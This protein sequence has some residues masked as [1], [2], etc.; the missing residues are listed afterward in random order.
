MVGWKIVDEN[1]DDVMTAESVSL[2]AGMRQ[3]TPRQFAQKE[4]RLLSSG[5]GDLVIAVKAA[6]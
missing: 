4:A 2:Y 6:A 5:G 1:G 3:I